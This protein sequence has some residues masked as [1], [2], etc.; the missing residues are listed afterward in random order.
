[1]SI[2][3]K[4]LDELVKNTKNDLETRKFISDLLSKENSGLGNYK[5]KYKEYIDKYSRGDINENN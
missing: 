2:N 1:M 5:E 3:T 4:I